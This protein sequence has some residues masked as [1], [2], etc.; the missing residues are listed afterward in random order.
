MGG[1]GGG[2]GRNFTVDR[3]RQ[4]TDYT[5]SGSAEE[6]ANN[7]AKM[8]RFRELIRGPNMPPPPP[9]PPPQGVD[10]SAML[11]IFKTLADVMVTA[12]RAVQ[13]APAPPAAPPPAPP[14]GQ[15]ATPAD[16]LTIANLE[17]MIA[18]LR[19]DKKN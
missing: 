9:P 14:A 13:A 4:T 6:W 17:R 15:L 2:Q 16:P 19:N 12:V 8:D 18:A 1:G 10:L 7:F 5:G 3:Q 11:T